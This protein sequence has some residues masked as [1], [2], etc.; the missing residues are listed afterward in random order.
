MSSIYGSALGANVMFEQNNVGVA[1]TSTGGNGGG[2]VD[3]NSFT[4]DDAD[5]QGI[6]LTATRVGSGISINTGSD[7]IGKNPTQISWMPFIT[8]SPSGG[9]LTCRI[10]TPDGTATGTLQA[11]STNSFTMAQWIANDASK[12]DFT[13]DTGYTLQDADTIIVYLDNTSGTDGGNF[14]TWAKSTYDDSALFRL[15]QYYGSWELGDDNSPY[16]QLTY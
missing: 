2:T 14:P 7:L 11:T 1:F 10:Y 8:G 6:S 16:F 4:N 15:V 13:F 12:T 3:S 9:N 5:A